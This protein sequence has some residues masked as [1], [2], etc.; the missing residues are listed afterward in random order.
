MQW[1][2]KLYKD[3]FDDKKIDI[4]TGLLEWKNIR[5][6]TYPFIWEKYWKKTKILFVWLDIWRDEKCVDNTY[7]KL[8]DRYKSIINE[9][10]VENYNTHISWTY[11][12]AINYIF[13]DKLT[14]KIKNMTFKNWIKELLK[15]NILENDNP[16]EYIALTNYYKFVT[17]GRCDRKWD[18]NRDYYIWKDEEEKLFLDEIEILDP[19]IIIFQSS[20]FKKMNNIEKELINKKNIK[21]VV[22]YHPSYRKWIKIKKY[23]EKY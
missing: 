1:I 23:L 13:E 20:R 12:T 6:A 18:E 16:L 22:L 21:I 7:Q 5:F 19:E 4:N 17:R 3:F 11:I 8:G 9:N 10:K 14:D 15:D 2:I